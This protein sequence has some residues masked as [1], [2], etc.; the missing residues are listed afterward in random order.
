[1]TMTAR[2][3]EAMIAYYAGDVRRISHFLTVYGFAK[4][5]GECERLDA[6]AQEILEI[7]ALTHDIGIKAGM[8]K[9]GKSRAATQQ[10]EG[11][12]AARAMLTALGC[13]ETVVDRVCW[14]I[15]R[16]HTFGNIAG[17]DYQILV[18]AD[19]LVNITG[20]AMKEATIRKLK[21]NVFRTETGL[22][23]LAAIYGV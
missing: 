1:M 14:L 13:P 3:T 18:E 12:P 8:E 5:I 22:R 21:K 19:L 16:H 6:P 10:T 11:P 2:V 7:A 15:S 20:H 23:F 17:K 9:F 4:A